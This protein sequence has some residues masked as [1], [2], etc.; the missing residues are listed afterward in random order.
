[1]IQYHVLKNN[2]NSFKLL[3]NVNKN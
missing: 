1:M 3:I 2:K